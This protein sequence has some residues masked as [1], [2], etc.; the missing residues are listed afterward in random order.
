MLRFPCDHCAKPL[1]I[2]DALAG[3]KAVCPYCRAVIAVPPMAAAADDPSVPEAEADD[4]PSE[5]SENAAPSGAPAKRQRNKSAASDDA[6]NGSSDDEPT[7][8]A[9]PVADGSDEQDILVVHPAWFVSRPGHAAIA[10]LAV[11]LGLGFAIGG[12]WHGIQV[13]AGTGG[14]LI[15]LGSCI[16]G[17]WYIHAR[18]TAITVTSKRLI[19]AQGL[20]TR[21]TLDV[22]LREIQDIRLTQSLHER[23]LGTGRLS[24]SNSSQSDD[25]VE[26]ENIPNPQSLKKAIDKARKL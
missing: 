11:L 4:H 19:I 13:L 9:D 1:R 23:L 16:L 22:P 14:G 10:V 2:D 21:D 25:E 3:K 5:S 8:A 20:F 26:L 24:I 7:A 12:L 17:Y 15:L 18:S 6:E